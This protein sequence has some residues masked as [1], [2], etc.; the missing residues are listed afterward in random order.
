MGNKEDRTKSEA[1]G[2][3]EKQLKNLGYS[4][5]V[6]RGINAFFR[7]IDYQKKIVY[8]A[9]PENKFQDELKAHDLA[10]ALIEIKLKIKNTHWTP[11]FIPELIKTVITHPKMY[12]LLSDN[13]LDI[14]EII[15]RKFE[16]KIRLIENASP[17]IN[18]YEMILNIAAEYSLFT[19]EQCHIIKKELLKKQHGDYAF[20]ALEQINEIV[21]GGEIKD[22]KDYTKRANKICEILAIDSFIKLVYEST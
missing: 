3:I 5:E 12:K 13:G 20:E 17:E 18:M 2:K 6:E 4:Y 14:S 7:G 10:H 16:E 19:D 1:L 9:L 8:I 21:T 15:Q 11:G 22:T